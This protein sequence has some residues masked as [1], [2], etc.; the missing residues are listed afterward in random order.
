MQPQAPSKTQRILP[1][2]EKIQ[3][4]VPFPINA[5]QDDEEPVTNRLAV[6][7]FCLAILAVVAALTLWIGWGF[8]FFVLVF[9]PLALALGLSARSQIKRNP[10]KYKN[11][12][13]ATV[14]I[15]V[16]ATALLVA[17]AF[18]AAVLI[19]LANFQ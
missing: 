15:M 19:A 3:R 6:W 16:G 5:A 18:S 17:A 14:A 12:F 1:S 13:F 4:L 7:A 2:P 8:S 11:K 9:A 10:E